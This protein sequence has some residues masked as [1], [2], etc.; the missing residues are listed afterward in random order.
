MS[1][2]QPLNLRIERAQVSASVFSTTSQTSLMRNC[3]ARCWFFISLNQVWRCP[4]TGICYSCGAYAQKSF[5]A[6]WKWTILTNEK[7]VGVLRYRVQMFVSDASRSDVFLAFDG[8]VT[9]LTNI[10]AAK[11]AH[12]MICDP[13]HNA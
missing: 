3:I 9:K 8:S 7:A 5:S 2:G 10:A 4:E 11:V 1:H 12:L 13:F 6:L